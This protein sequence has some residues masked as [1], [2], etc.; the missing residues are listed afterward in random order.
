[1]YSIGD[2]V[3][4]TEMV[5]YGVRWLLVLTNVI[6]SLGIQVLNNYGVCLSLIYDCVSYILIKN[7]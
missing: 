5:L 7:Y 1:M 4:N 3:S 2:I 6:A